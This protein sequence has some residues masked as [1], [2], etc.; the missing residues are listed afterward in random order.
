MTKD[1]LP[2]VRSKVKA[3]EE[4]PKTDAPYI[5]ESQLYQNCRTRTINIPVVNPT[6]NATVL[7]SIDGS[8]PSRKLSG[9]SQIAVENGFNKQKTPEPDKSIVI[10][11]KAV[12]NGIASEVNS[13][14]ITMH[15]DYKVWDG[16]EI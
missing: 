13:F 14:I 15:K 3:P 9:N 10:K 2:C 6:A 7:F 1:Y 16:Y 12:N 11:L 4:K 8:E 5:K